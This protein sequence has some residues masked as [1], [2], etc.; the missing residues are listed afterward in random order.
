MY[1]LAGARIGYALAHPDT[2]KLLNSMQP[3]PNAGASATAIAAAG[4]SLDDTGFFKMVVEKNNEEKQKLYNLFTL[5]NLPFI[6]S[7][8]NFVYYS[9]NRYTGDF[10]KEMEKRNILCGGMVEEKEKWTRITV[11][12]A[13]EMDTYSK[14][15]KEIIV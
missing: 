13:S 3:W 6:E 12:T 10:Q 4:A 7:H 15:L 2:I 14:A 11:G 1:G 8:S 5:M 9:I